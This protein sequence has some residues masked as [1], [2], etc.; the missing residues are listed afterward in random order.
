MPR[1]RAGAEGVWIF[2]RSPAR[3]SPQ[4]FRSL[5]SAAGKETRISAKGGFLQRGENRQQGWLRRV[6]SKVRVKRLPL[7]ALPEKSAA[8]NLGVNFIWC[9]IGVMLKYV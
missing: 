3:V 2:R 8:E 9:C 4:F 1:V 6:Q 5:F 7:G